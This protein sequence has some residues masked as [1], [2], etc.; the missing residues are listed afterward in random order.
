MKKFFNSYSSAVVALSGGADSSAVLKLA[1]DYIGIKNVV[2]ATCVNH[3]VFL[4]EIENARII[5]DFFS[6]G[7]KPFYISPHK[8]FLE[9]DTLKCYHCKASVLSYLERYRH[10]NNIDVIF[11]GTNIDD[12]NDF[13]PGMKA[14]E[15][16]GIVSPL[17][18]F[19]LGKKDSLKILKDVPFRFHSE[20]CVATRIS[21]NRIDYEDI[22]KIEQI[23]NILRQNYPGIRVRLGD[24]IL[25]EFKQDI[26]ISPLDI[27]FFSKII[28]L[29][30]EKK[31]ITV[32]HNGG[33]SVTERKF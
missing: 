8:K 10:F 21:G 5:S 1:A 29:F 18:E 3:H 13:R 33:N 25:V 16:F 19:E 31:R 6:T 12:L 30:Y 20:S 11:D 24:E 7:W 27:E 2:A 14:L 4:Y 15:E 28:T 26:K 22:Y 9:N 23:E 17:K 32:K